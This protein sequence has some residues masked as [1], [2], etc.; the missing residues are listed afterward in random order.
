MFV[1][2]ASGRT[3]LRHDAIRRTFVSS[4]ETVE[5]L[6]NKYCA[7]RHGQSKANVAKVIS[8][9]PEVATVQHG[10]SPNGIEQATKAGED[11]AKYFHGSKTG[12]DGMVILASD[13]LRA[14]ETAECV[15]EIVARS[16]P[17]IP[18]L[19]GGV[20]LEKDL[21]ERWFGNWDGKP[22]VHYPDVWKDD[23]IDADHTKQ[24]V[25]SVNSVLK[26]AT[27][28]VTMWDERVQNHLI[29]LVAHGDVLQITQTAFARIDGTLH[30]TLPHLETATLRPLELAD[31]P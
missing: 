17:A 26:R 24:D 20:I 19:D 7:L 28:C 31:K 9:H 23:A 13:Y 12:Y 22:D 27:G 2:K 18:L 5:T 16:D 10:L 3:L 1:R 14:K 4:L 8:S 29:L 21:R 25:E 6:R 11:T 15:A 30:R